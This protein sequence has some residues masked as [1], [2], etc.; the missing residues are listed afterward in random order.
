MWTDLRYSVRMLVKSPGFA[1]VAT[2]TLALGIGSNTAIFTVANTLLLRPLPYTDPGR[3][4]LLFADR[5]GQLEGF[6][7]LRY[8]LLR[9]QTRSF[10][11]VAVF[12]SDTFN[13]TSRGN[14][15]GRGD[16]EQL[17]SARV[18]ANFFDVLGVR[19]EL[20]RAFG[21]NGDQPEAKPEVMISHTL[22]LRRFGAEKDI[23][24]ESIALD[25][26]DYTIIGVLPSSF[27]FSE[28]R[29]NVDIWSPR[30]FEHSLASAER[31]RLGVGYLYGI[32]RLASGTT[33]DQ[34]QA[35]MDV[36]NGQYQRDNPG[37]PDVDT[38]Q[39]V[40]V[41]DLQQQ[42]VANF[43]PALLVLMGAV[44]FVLLIACANV[45]SLLLSRALGRK[46]EIAVRAALGASRGAL[47]RQLIV[48][49]LLLAMVSGI[50][51]ILL[52]QWCTHM[53]ASLTLSNLP[54]MAGVRMDLPVLAFTVAISLASGILF[55]LTPALQLSKPDLNTV[56]RDEGRGSTGSR[57]RNRARSLMVIAQ[58]ALSM[59]LLVGS[60][61]LIRSFVRLQTVNL[62]FDPARILTMRIALPPTKYATPQQQ[63]AFYDR[64]LKAVQTLPGV[65]AASISSALPLNPSRQSP[66][67]P[68]GQ[69]MVPFGQRPILN[70]QTISPDYARVLRMPLLR[71]R[72]FTDHDGADA[73]GVAIVNEAVVRRYWPNDNPI[74]KHI[75]LGQ[76]PQPVE[77]VGVFSDLK[78]VTLGDDASPEVILPF[79][80]LPWPLLNLSVRTA[81]DPR[82]LISAVRRQVSDV[83]KDQPLTDVRTMD[84]VVGSA[85][86][87]Q[88]LTMLLLGVFSA[89]ALILA[90]V[91]IYGVIAYSVAQRTQELGI[92][93]ALGADPG[94]VLKLVVGQGLGLTLTGIAIGL[95]GAFALTRLMSSLL[96]QT[97]ATDPIAFAVS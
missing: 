14:L 97:S 34:A 28:L 32:A 49:S 42:V 79:P 9:V 47:I 53:L 6:S 73:P 22:W 94:D 82:S 8:S 62:G 68:E 12:A 84:E 2:L 60:G 16:P 41:R 3:L 75:L 88:R 91:G 4:A 30:V 96:Y 37:R 57:G 78:N 39:K 85:T 56:L 33:R 48:E 66:M 50:C 89:T 40:V 69:P 87:P 29:A 18:S 63:I 95:A 38:N 54:S 20:G 74:G 36:L 52:S 45:A 43:R 83:D 71:G 23:I 61:L 65:Q 5:R 90:M 35:E 44:G 26:R 11:G 21:A 58:V 86:A 25:S 24:G 27:T 93:M 70:I 31:V 51:G 10:S 76:R 1:L 59:V 46:K 81:G 55:G 17:S 64:V 80:Q 67:L 19:P 15:T 7:Y 77:V 72:E 13:L 92:R